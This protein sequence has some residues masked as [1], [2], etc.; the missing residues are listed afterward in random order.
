MKTIKKEYIMAG[1]T[2]ILWSTLPSVSKLIINEL[3]PMSATFYA[4][5]IAAVTLL[6]SVSP[7]SVVQ[8][9]VTT[10]SACSG[11]SCKES[12]AASVVQ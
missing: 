6:V 11:A 8:L 7:A 4:S 1:T 9:A 3:S 12:P 10:E 5:L 2:V